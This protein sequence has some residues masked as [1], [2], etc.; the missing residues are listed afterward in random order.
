MDDNK[1]ETLGE[2]RSVKWK[3][4]KKKSTL[5]LCP[6]DDNLDHYCKRAN[7]LSYIQLH[8]KV[9]N[10]PSLIGHG[11]MLLDG[12]F[13]PVRNRLPDL[14]NN[15]KKPV[16]DMVLI[17]DAMVKVMRMNVLAQTTLF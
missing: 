2:A 9:Y 16:V 1:S 12:S 7:Y 10:H 14:P 5:R 13:R 15:V 17:C 8:P 6:V 11:W 3:S 4:M